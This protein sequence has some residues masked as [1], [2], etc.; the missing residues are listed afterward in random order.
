M[1]NLFLGLQE[2][3]REPT[4]GSWSLLESSYVCISKDL[5][6]SSLGH[7]LSGP[8]QDVTEQILTFTIQTSLRFTKMYTILG[9]KPTKK[10][11]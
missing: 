1:C 6:L 5:F 7:F 2:N 11:L 10:P 9:Q 8:F 3:I 4:D